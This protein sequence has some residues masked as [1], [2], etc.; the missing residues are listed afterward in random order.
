MSSNHLLCPVLALAAGGREDAERGARGA[1]PAPSWPCWQPILL[2][3]LGSVLS[4]LSRAAA[5]LWSPPRTARCCATGRR[6]VAVPEGIPTET[7]LLDLGKNRI[8]RSTRARVCQLPHLEE[9]ELNENIVAVELAPST[10]SS[11][12]GP[13]APQQ[14]PEAH[15]PE[16][17]FTGLSNLT[18]LDISEN[19]IVILLDYMFQDLYNLKSLEV[20]ERPRLHLPPSLQRPQ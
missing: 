12:S 4:R 15:P 14:P 9:L 11:T 19:K 7:R 6:F 16:A 10:T 18:K 13:W 3:V 20:G 17:S 1:C 5:P 2:L 8:R